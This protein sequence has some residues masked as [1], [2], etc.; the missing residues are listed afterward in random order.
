MSTV[1]LRSPRTSSL[2]RLAGARKAPF[3]RFIAPCDPVQHETPPVGPGWLYEIKVDGYRAQLHVHRGDV[4]VYS[5]RGLD[6]T[7]QFSAI[8]DAAA[9]LTDHDLVIDG[10]AVVYG[11]TGLP[12]FQQLRRELGEH[13]S[14]R[15]AY[16][17]FDLL[18]L[19]GYDLRG[20]A[21]V[22]RKRRLEALLGK[23]P[24]TFIYVEYLEANG[25]R[26]FAHGCEMGLEG[27]VAKRADAPYRSG[28]SDA[29][30]KVKCVKSETFPIVA[31]V[32]KL[33]ARPRK[34]ASL[35]VGK[36]EGGKLLYAGKAR[37]GYTETVAREL[38][39]RLD[40]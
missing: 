27:L 23:A 2:A 29:W 5:R 38:R 14:G 40:P 13:K 1:A 7:A 37:S 16:H 18:Y 24:E 26:V 10:E 6:W 31:F 36:R 33:G 34:I 11:A 22:E 25:R 30:V 4:R 17:A 20:V 3:P 21:Y 35:Y 19:D 15:L 28:R 12:D 8:A 9:S 32:E 39:E